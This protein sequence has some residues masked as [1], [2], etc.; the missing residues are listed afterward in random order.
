MASSFSDLILFNV[1]S[2]SSF[3][4]CSSLTSSGPLIM[5]GISLSV[6]LGGILS[7]L[8]KCSFHFQSLPSGLATF[9]FS[10]DELFFLLNSFTDCHTFRDCLS[11]IELLILSIWPWMYSNYSFWYV[12]VSS[13]RAL[14]FCTLAFVGFLLSLS[15]DAFLKL[16]RFGI[17][18]VNE[19]SHHLR[20]RPLNI[21][22]HFCLKRYWLI[23]T[24]WITED[25]NS[26]NFLNLCS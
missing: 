16:S 5:F 24:F 4:N 20:Y 19:E 21:K 22:E 12:L 1:A 6:I 23:K 7:G 18:W 15:K 11:S 13:F 14:S 2:S 26:K 8:L 25:E 9:S 10:L 17:K 3:L